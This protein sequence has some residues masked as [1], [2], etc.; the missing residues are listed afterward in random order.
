MPR[1][2]SGVGSTLHKQMTDAVGLI[3]LLACLS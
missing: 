3:A 1:P 2:M